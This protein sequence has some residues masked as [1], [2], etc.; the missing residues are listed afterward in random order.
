[1]NLFTLGHDYLFILILGMARILPIALFLPWFNTQVLG[2]MI[3]KNVV[4]F[5]LLLVF[6]LF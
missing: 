3:V 2:G 6:S 5:L 1:M 4:V